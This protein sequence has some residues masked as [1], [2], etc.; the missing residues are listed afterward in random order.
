MPRTRAA[1]AGKTA[2]RVGLVVKMML[3]RSSATARLRS[4]MAPRSSAV[5]S[6]MS[7]SL[8]VAEVVAPLIAHTRRSCLLGDISPCC[9]IPL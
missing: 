2:L 6:T 9:L 3:M 8:L 5:A 4:S 7:A 1:V